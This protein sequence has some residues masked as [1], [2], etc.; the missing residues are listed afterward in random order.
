MGSSIN[1][2]NT[3]STLTVDGKTYQYYAINGGD[4]SAHDSVVRLPV[5]SKILLEN[6]LR[7]EDGISCTRE[8][9]EELVASGGCA[10]DQEIAYHPTRVL[11]QD[12][13]GVPAVVDLAAMRNALVQ[14]GVDPRKIN[15]L[16][17]VDLVIDHSVSIDKFGTDSAFEQNVAMEM[18]RNLE[19]YQFLK[20]GQGAFDDFR[21]VP[22]G[23][24]ICHQVNL[25]YL[26]QV[27]WQQNTADIPIACP[28]TLVGTDS[29]VFQGSCRIHLRGD[30]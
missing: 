30:L 2:F 19:R 26:A 24:G 7:H 6:L 16:T 21:V 28:D 22:P 27:V 18:Q 23:T 8:D 20:W 5:C 9:I 25:E 12:F 17:P 29:A 1:S 10:S 3:R 4:L 15:P 14:R 13:T 11:M